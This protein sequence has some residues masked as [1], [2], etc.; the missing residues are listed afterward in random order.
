[1]LYLLALSYL[2][3]LALTQ[4]YTIFLSCGKCTL[5]PGCQFCDIY[6]GGP[7]NNYP[8]CSTTNC[9]GLTTGTFQLTFSCLDSSGTCNYNY[10]QSGQTVTEGTTTGDDGAWGIISNNLNNALQTMRGSHTPVNY[11]WCNGVG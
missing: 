6:N 5:I 3:T 9:N 1:M 7:F 11:N 2:I 4:T 8:I 10:A